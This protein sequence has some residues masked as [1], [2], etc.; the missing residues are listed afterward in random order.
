MERAQNKQAARAPGGGE[1]AE[2]RWRSAVLATA[3]TQ[4]HWVEPATRKQ[5]A[6]QLLRKLF[7]DANATSSTYCSRDGHYPVIISIPQC[8]KN[9]HG[10]SRCHY[11]YP[12]VQ[13][14]HTHTRTC[15]NAR[16]GPHVCPR[17]LADSGCGSPPRLS[18]AA[19]PG[20]GDKASSSSEPDRTADKRGQLRKFD[21]NS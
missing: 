2:Q 17:A 15:P 11:F 19:P 1:R 18:P 3:V 21:V 14:S 7:Q 13:F 9:T 16:L 6:M 8:T 5:R 10:E 4:L 12:T 20:A